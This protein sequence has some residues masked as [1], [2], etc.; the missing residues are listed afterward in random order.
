MRP[1]L[2]FPP[3]LALALLAS[4]AGAPRG[5]VDPGFDFG[6]VVSYAWKEAPRFAAGADDGELRAFERRVERVLERR[7]IGLVEKRRA[8][9]LLSGAIA[10]EERERQLDPN[11]SVHSAEKYELAVMTLEVYDR[12]RRAL[13]WA[14][15]EPL[16]LRTV[17]RRFGRRLVED[18][19]PTGD[20]RRWRVDDMVDA[21]LARLPR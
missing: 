11:Y 6:D 1:A 9:V 5:V 21:L 19:T 7:G 13:V 3:G 20:D 18:W 8:Q 15:D 10:I 4:C 2:L 12:R 16:P 17:G 14:D